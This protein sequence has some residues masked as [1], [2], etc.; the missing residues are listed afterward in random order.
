MR[1]YSKIDTKNKIINNNNNEKKL[2]KLKKK[3][4]KVWDTHTNSIYIMK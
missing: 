3:R 2:I 4:K 1:I